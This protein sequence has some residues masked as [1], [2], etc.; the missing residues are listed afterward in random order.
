MP[1][2]LISEGEKA[3]V[4]ARG[5]LL[6]QSPINSTGFHTLASQTKVKS[7]LIWPEAQLKTTKIRSELGT[8]ISGCNK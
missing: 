8:D 7:D 1:G 6:G 3:A 4:A 5:H 2:S